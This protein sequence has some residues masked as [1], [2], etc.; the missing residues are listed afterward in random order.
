MSTD[1]NGRPTGN[2]DAEH[3]AARFAADCA[4]QLD[5]CASLLAVA[6]RLPGSLNVTTLDV[7]SKLV[8]ATWSSHLA[9]IGEAILPLVERR[10][11]GMHDLHTRFTPLGRQHIE[12]SGINDELIECFGMITRGE[13]VEQGMLGYLIRNAAER[14]REHV[15]WE[16]ALLG[17]LLPQTLTPTERK[18]FLKWTSANPWPYE[19]LNTRPIRDVH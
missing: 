9:L 1:D 14:R 3:P 5:I 15:E 13:P 18:V 17:P 2:V 6:D 12:I 8:P 11:E 4:L 16:Q 19:L 10:H 7:L